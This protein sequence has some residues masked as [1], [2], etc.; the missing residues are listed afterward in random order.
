MKKKI[1]LG[2]EVMVS[3][4]CYEVPTWCQIKVYD[5]LPGKYGT[6]VTKIDLGDW[7]K[8]IGYLTAIHEDYLD[9]ELKWK[10]HS[11]EV[12]VDSGQ[13]GIFSMETYRDDSIVG[14]IGLGD[15]DIKF[16]D[17]FPVSGDKDSGETWYRA[18]CSRTLGKQQWGTY[19]NGV[20][21]SS[22]LGDGSYVLYVA[23]VNRKVVGF[24]IDFG[25]DEEGE[26]PPNKK[27]NKLHP[28]L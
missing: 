24:C 26:F 21:S 4:P 14:K 12:G 11:G 15:G 23:K 2:K 19:N 9:Q 8:R 17:D 20:V 5:V 18:I 22:G 13:A 1:T 10:E 3:D 28:M 6:D 25:V 16:F 7:G 27:K